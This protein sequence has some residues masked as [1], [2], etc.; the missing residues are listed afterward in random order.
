MPK[1]PSIASNALSVDVGKIPRSERRRVA[2]HCQHGRDDT[3][4]IKIR[5]R[6]FTPRNLASDPAK[7]KGRC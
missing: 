7:I 6:E 5:N 4:N 1:I 2:Y 3:V